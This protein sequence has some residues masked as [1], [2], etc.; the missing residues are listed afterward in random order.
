VRSLLEQ[1]GIKTVFKTI[2]PSESADVTPIVQK[3]ASK[4]PDLIVGGTQSTD[5]FAIVKALVQ[6]RYNPKYLFLSN[7]PNDPAEF[8]SKVGPK[9]VN[10]IF[11]TGDWFANSPA[12]GNKQFVASYLKAYGGDR[13][14]IDPTSAEAYAVGQVAEAAIKK[15]GAVDNK[16]IINVLHSGS[17]PTVEGVLRWNS[18]GEPQGSDL[19]VQWVGGRLLPV[20]PKSVAAHAPI[21][22][23]AWGH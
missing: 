8:P 22:K 23:P 19:L 3:L 16:K 7:G 1:K 20:Y 21:A 17:W 12:P 4:K 13:Y 2:Y 14:T 15:V 5:A 18:I 6:L 9:N 10:G 11:S